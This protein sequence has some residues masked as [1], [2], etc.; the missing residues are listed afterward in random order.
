MKIKQRNE[1]SNITYITFAKRFADAELLTTCVKGL[2]CTLYLSILRCPYFG[3]YYS[4]V[5]NVI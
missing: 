4:V 1:I 5:L 3:G 2:N